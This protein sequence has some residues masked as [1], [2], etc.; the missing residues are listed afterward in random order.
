LRK[1]EVRRGKEL[2]ELLILMFMEPSL[3]SCFSFL[4]QI[5]QRPYKELFL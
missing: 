3:I 1:D 4:T 2:E 5:L